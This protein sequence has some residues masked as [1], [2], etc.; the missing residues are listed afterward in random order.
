MAL[1]LR[2][3]A[4]VLAGRCGELKTLTTLFSRACR[5]ELKLMAFFLVHCRA[6]GLWRCLYIILHAHSCFV[7]LH[8]VFRG[9]AGGLPA[10]PQ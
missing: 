10:A 3:R 5:N 4:W 2:Q 9:S 1:W 8:Q 6:G 7:F